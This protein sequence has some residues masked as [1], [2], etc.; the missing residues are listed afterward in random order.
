MN[1]SNENRR[2]DRYKSLAISK[3]FWSDPNTVGWGILAGLASAPLV[4]LGGTIGVCIGNRFSK[5]LL[6]RLVFGLLTLIALNSIW[7]VWAR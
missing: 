2:F 7:S 4:Y 6:R 5:L 3:L 1:T